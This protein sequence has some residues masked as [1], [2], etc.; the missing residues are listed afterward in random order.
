MHR[1]FAARQKVVSP[2]EMERLCNRWSGD[3]PA[4]AAVWGWVGLPGHLVSAD[5]SG[6]L[7]TAIMSI[8]DDHGIE[9]MGIRR[10]LPGLRIQA[11]QI[12]GRNYA[13]WH[14]E[15]PVE[16]EMAFYASLSGPEATSATARL[17]K[18]NLAD[19][20]A[21]LRFHTS[22]DVECLSSE[23]L[24]SGQSDRSPRFTIYASELARR[25]ERTCDGPLFLSWLI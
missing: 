8:A 7:N 19:A 3:L 10:W 1:E 20:R 25:V 17:L 5:V 24:E 12:L 4:L 21:V 11:L 22:S 16:H 14:Y 6:A 2:S 18:I 9:L 15:G 13:N 23:E